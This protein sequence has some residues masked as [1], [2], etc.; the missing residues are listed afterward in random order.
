M[1]QRQML[2]FLACKNSKYETGQLLVYSLLTPKAFDKL[3]EHNIHSKSTDS[4][5]YSLS[6]SMIFAPGI[7]AAVIYIF[8]IFLFSVYLTLTIIIYN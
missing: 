6:A 7:W 4:S 1:N 8:L 5:L 2:Q 3:V